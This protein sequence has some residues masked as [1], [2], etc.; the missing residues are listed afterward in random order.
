MGGNDDGDAS[1]SGSDDGRTSESSNDAGAGRI[2]DDDGASRAGDDAATRSS[3]PPPREADPSYDLSVLYAPRAVLAALTVAVVLAVVVAA[4][5]TS[6]AFGVYNAAW[7]GAAG[8]DDVAGEAGVDARVVL[9]ADAYPTDPATANGTVAV[10]LAPESAYAP[11][12]V[13]R[14]DRFVAAGG[15]LVVAEDFGAGGND[16]LAALGTATR[17]DGRLVR[18]EREPYRSPAMPLATGVADAPLTRGVDRLTLNHGT[19]LRVPNGSATGGRTDAGTGNASD[20]ATAPV[21]V[22]VRTSPYAYLDGDR[23]GELDDDESLA[24]RPVVAVE[25]VGDGRVVAVSDP[26]LFIN[27]MLERPGNRQFVRNLAADA[28]VTD[29][30]TGTGTGTGSGAATG[31]TSDEGPARDGVVTASPTPTPTST[32]GERVLLD[33]SHAGGQPPLAVALLVVRDAPLLQALLGG[34]G[35]GAVIAWAGR[36]ALR[37][38]ARELRST[39]SRPDR[40]DDGAGG[41]RGS[42]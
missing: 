15:T 9:D 14:L 33:Y 38:R 4:S 26:S 10:V 41:R 27:A 37:A 12:E 7:D 32:A 6:A 11:A 16:L 2:R 5:T 42:S 35:I 13:D 31:A 21:R 19:V 24:A 36:G 34:A 30:G 1:R 29:N 25:R 28:P 40:D 8:L 23:D 3:G 20:D 17:F 39:G 18:D 22:L